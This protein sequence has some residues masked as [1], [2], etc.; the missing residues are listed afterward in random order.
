MPGDKA[1]LLT[2]VGKD[3]NAFSETPIDVSISLWDLTSGKRLAGDAIKLQSAYHQRYVARCTP[4]GR[5]AIAN[6]DRKTAK[7]VEVTLPN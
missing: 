6:V 5:F 7:I 1:R 3:E 4:D 2:I